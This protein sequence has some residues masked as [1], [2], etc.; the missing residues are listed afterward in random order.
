MSMYL[1]EGISPEWHG[2]VLNIFRKMQTEIDGKI[3]TIICDEM[4]CDLTELR[5]WLATKREP[6]IVLDWVRHLS[7]EELARLLDCTCPPPKSV[8]HC[9]IEKNREPNPE[10]CEKCWLKWLYRSVDDEVRRVSG[11]QNPV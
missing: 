10:E 3:E 1:T 9:L 8:S 7:A 5:E 6:K 11:F 4:Q 2:N